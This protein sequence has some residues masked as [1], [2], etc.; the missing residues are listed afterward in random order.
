MRHGEKQLPGRRNR[1]ERN[2]T[3]GG[4]GGREQAQGAG[5]E[6]KVGQEIDGKS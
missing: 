4:D 1:R 6:K 5:R 2:G 3:G